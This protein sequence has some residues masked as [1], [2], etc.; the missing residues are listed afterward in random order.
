MLSVHWRC[1][2]RC[3][4]NLWLRHLILTHSFT[5]KCYGLF[6]VPRIIAYAEN[7]DVIIEGRERVRVNS[8]NREGYETGT[9]Y[10]RQKKKQVQKQAGR[11]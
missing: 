7:E 11:R 9:G 6:Y 4:N 5:E 3:C 2:L 8:V 1:A 10:T